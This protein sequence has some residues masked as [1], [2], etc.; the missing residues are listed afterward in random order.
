MTAAINRHYVAF[1]GIFEVLLPEERQSSFLPKYLQIFHVPLVLLFGSLNYIL[2]TNQNNLEAATNGDH[3]EK[4][5]LTG[6]Q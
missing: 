4:E 3:R 2:P 5:I 1:E 6:T